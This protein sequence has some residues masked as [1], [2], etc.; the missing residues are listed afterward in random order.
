[1]KLRQERVALA[2]PTDKAAGS[3]QVRRVPDA[4]IADVDRKMA[5]GTIM[6]IP[7]AMPPLIPA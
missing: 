4:V 7:P 6:A 5:A 3:Q 2:C 1:M